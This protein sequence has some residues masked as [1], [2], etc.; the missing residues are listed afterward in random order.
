[1][2]A[3]DD[4]LKDDFIYA[5]S[6]PSHPTFERKMT[7]I[8]AAINEAAASPPYDYPQSRVFHFTRRIHEAVRV[9]RLC[10]NVSLSKLMI[11]FTRNASSGTVCKCVRKLPSRQLRLHQLL[12]RRRGR[13]R[14]W[15]PRI[16]LTW[17]WSFR[18][19][20]TSCPCVY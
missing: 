10:P 19:L 1:M 15:T 8:Q 11:Y 2:M 12:Q 3:F 4:E 13:M 14:S 16:V 17:T 5:W 6:L 7:L 9:S 20:S 18:D